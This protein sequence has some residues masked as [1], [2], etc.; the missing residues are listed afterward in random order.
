[1]TDGKINGQVA[2]HETAG[3]CG[4]R[5]AIDV[6]PAQGV[7]GPWMHVEV[8][9]EYLADLIRTALVAAMQS[10]ARERVLRMIRL[11]AE[12]VA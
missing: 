1:M 10:S 12:G 7:A 11:L 3:P 6:R 9:G 2:G 4:D 8:S 5:L